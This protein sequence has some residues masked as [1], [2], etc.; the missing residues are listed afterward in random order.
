M[1]SLL[2]KGE[3]RTWLIFVVV[4]LIL[5]AAGFFHAKDSVFSKQALEQ[6]AGPG[7]GYYWAASQYRYAIQRI[8]GEAGAY[9]LGEESWSDFQEAY[10]VLQSKF[11][12]LT[13]TIPSKVSDRPEFSGLLEQTATIMAKIHA[14]FPKGE[15]DP[16]AMK[17]LRA[18]LQQLLPIGSKLAKAS[19]EVEVTLRDL[20]I[21][22]TL[23]LRNMAL[24]SL[25]GVWLALVVFLARELVR[26]R[27]RQ[28]TIELQNEAILAARQSRDEA[29]QTALA[30]S[31]LL[32]TVSH[33]ILTPLSTIQGGV[34]LLSDTVTT[35]RAI[36]T[37]SNIRSAAEY[38]GRL[39]QDLLDMERL[40]AGK[41]VLRP[42]VFDP[43]QLV[44]N[45][46]GEY[47]RAT[48]A[49]GIALSV[50]ATAMVSSMVYADMTRVRQVINNLVSNAVRYTDEGKI[51]IKLDQELGTPAKLVVTVSDTGVGIPANERETL[52]D[53]FIQGSAAGRGGAGMGLSIV[54]RLIALMEGSVELAASD[55]GKGSMFIA[56]MPV[57]I[58]DDD[59]RALRESSPHTGEGQRLL[60]VED[61]DNL[62]E[63]LVDVL[64][65]YGFNCDT[66]RTGEGAMGKL[67]D[68]HYDAIVLDIKLPDQNGLEMLDRLRMGNSENKA[69]PVIGISANKDNFLDGRCSMLTAKLTKPFRNRV[70]V[71]NLI[72]LG[73]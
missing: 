33:E 39:M 32:S 42:S 19:H 25:V 1:Q 15:H 20:S 37:L 55:V 51:Q 56:K 3:W 71:E 6:A 9:T 12:V 40:D 36:R 62:R 2:K 18:E 21:E 24:A 5:P 41:L 48:K 10:D 30:R 35:P 73:A 70:L 47:E 44:V 53:P 46:A 61:D 72:Q 64:Q 27:R 4:A 57:T 13:N 59:T 58:V 50:E 28:E 69:V 22:Q 43:R 60:I 63:M 67:K 34:D 49:K 8:Y 68:A 54:R 52:F 65:Y 38:L 11:L 23:R 31:T 26:A 45:V 66:S 14:Q 7:E 17:V 29:E 16:T